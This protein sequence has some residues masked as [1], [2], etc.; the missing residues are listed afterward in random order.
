M[1]PCQLGKNLNLKYKEVIEKFQKVE[2]L[3]LEDFYCINYNGSN[4]TLYSH[5]SVAIQN[6]TYFVLKISSE[7]K[8]FLLGV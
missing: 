5:P 7:C 4:F 8:S 6:E 2:N 3:K 1:E